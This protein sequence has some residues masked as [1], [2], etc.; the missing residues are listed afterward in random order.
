MQFIKPGDWVTPTKNMSGIG[1]VSPVYA[2]IGT[3]MQ[4]ATYPIAA[5]VSGI[6][7]LVTRLRKKAQ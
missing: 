2:H 3:G 6:G 5:T 7:A 1:D 4:V